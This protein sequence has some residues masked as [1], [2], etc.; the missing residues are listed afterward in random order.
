MVALKKTYAKIVAREIRLSISRFLAIFA[1][2][3]LGVGFLAGLLSATPDMR[4]SADAYYDDT[5]MMDLRVLSSLGLS[6]EDIGAIRET[7]GVAGVMPAYTADV[8]LDGEE[9]NG[10]AARIHSL[11]LDKLE[12][13][14]SDAA[15]Q[16]RVIL[17]KGRYPETRGEVVALDALY[18]G[19]AELG[20]TFTLSAE[21]AD[22][23][24][25]LRADTFTVVGIVR[26]SYY[27]SIERENSTVGNGR[28]ALTLF[29]GE[30]NF[31]Y[32]A[33]TDAFV[34]AEGAKE[35]AAFTD[36]YD[37]VVERVQDTLEALG[38][39]RASIRFE[40]VRREAQE[41]LD[42]GKAEYDSQKAEAG[43]QLEDAR[44]KLD[45]G[46]RDLEQGERKLADSKATL[47]DSE[48]KL[49]DGKKQLAEGE[50][51][52]AA[53]KAALEAQMKE[54][55]AKLDGGRQELLAGQSELE[56]AKAAL[57]EAKA[58]ID[59]AEAAIAALLAAGQTEQAA[60]AAAALEP[61]KSAYETG[62]AA[63]TE[64]A[65]VLAEKTAALDAG[66]AELDNGRRAAETEWTA[67]Q[68]TLD[69][70]RRRIEE[71]EQAVQKGKE[72]IA[73]AEKTLADARRELEEGETAYA[74]SKQEADDKLA[75]AARELDDAQKAIDDM[76][77]PEWYV[78]DRHTNVSYVSFESNA[79]KVGAI[80]QVFP[81]FFFLVAA[82]V[83]LTTMTRMVEEQRTQTG[84]LKALGY[85]NGAIAFRFLFYAGSASLLG[86]AAGLLAGL[87]VFP[88]VIWNAYAM[89]YSL[90]PLSV[91]FFPAI[92]LGTSLTAIVCTMLATLGAC[93][94][95][96]RERPAR[97]MLPKAPKAGRRIFLEHLSPIWKRMRFTHKVTARNLLRYKKRFFMTIT[98]IAGCTA[99]LVTGFGLRDSIR[100][101]TGKQFGELYQ[102]NLT[103]GIKT[104]EA[105]Q[106]DEALKNVL[107]DTQKIT[108]FLQIHQETGDAVSGKESLSVTIYVP[109]EL[110]R[111]PDFQVLRERKSGETVTLQADRVLI[112]EK[113]AE[114]LGLSPG[115]PLT[116]RNADGKTAD[117][118]LG[119]VIENYFQGG[120]FMPS[121]LYEQAFGQ[122]PDYTTLWVKV[123]DPT[124]E[125]R[126]A[127]GAAL[128]ETTPVQSVSF[129]NDIEESFTN[130]L[131]SID[132]IVV[133]LILSAA[134]LAFVVLYNLTNI[135]IAER[136]KE[137]ATIKVLGFYDREVSAYI[138][139]ETAILT[140]IGGL[141]GLV[142]GIFFHAFVVKTAEVDMIMFG[143]EI[144]WLS[145]VL[146]FVLTLFFSFLVNLVMGHKL[147]KIDMVESM[148]AGE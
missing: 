99:L 13:E 107:E 74:S 34:L 46:R 133:V 111:L 26:S 122:P 144:Q 112:T 88:R 123:P 108:G 45:G 12:T 103:V 76:E 10:A 21:N 96:L 125:R 105:V 55:Q 18:G 37:G 129:T 5:N 101:I 113:Q 132:S 115:D 31:A 92:A 142:V 145:Y 90:P 22:L 75:S 130:M 146:S 57:D 138:Y 98:G 114:L 47:A 35:K 137:I 30:D 135:N 56:A 29:A 63:Y 43:K 82:L 41:E 48:K 139:R 121:A 102:Y 86:S 17:T 20:D 109:N 78:L 119:G 136:Q 85:T 36:G 3:A 70:S 44:K 104:E 11:P 68:D 93:A 58:A 97:L 65:A 25:T 124:P 128:L 131:G 69:A 94:G 39:T 117:V 42:K 9:I 62:L 49:E 84:T 127:I 6:E 27:F 143:R 100:D 50:E 73:D 71:S 19:G 89:M 4:L 77:K 15:Y 83:A 1:I 116:L 64:Q 140:V 40:D 61:Q 16:N 66:Q 52:L 7:D 79:E 60:A 32:P 51:Q 87:E 134:A 67:A 141:A 24:D 95:S 28:I 148:K 80:A 2:V 8:L 54:A 118:L 72:E 147:K 81:V 110:E 106:T 14:P 120:V 33:Y 23:S 59:Q 53:Q 126:S 38:K 91:R